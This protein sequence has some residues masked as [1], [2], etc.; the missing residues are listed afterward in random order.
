MMEKFRQFMYGRYGVDELYFFLLVLYFI[1]FIV[2]CFVSS[3]AVNIVSLVILALA[4]FRSMSRNYEKRRKENK[5]FLKLYRPV[6][7]EMI[8]LKDRI[9]DFKTARYRKCPHCAITIKLPNKK[10]KHTVVC[11]KCR[12]RLNVHIVI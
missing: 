2:N 8:L 11:P 9:K 4:I 1:L 12:K 6:K 7:S 10:G 3:L 5:M